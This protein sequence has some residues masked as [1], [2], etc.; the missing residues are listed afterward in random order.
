MSEFRT[1]PV[2]ALDCGGDSNACLEARLLRTRIDRFLAEFDCTRC[3]TPTSGS[4]PTAVEVRSV[5]RSRS[6]RQRYFEPKFC[7][8]PAWDMLLE[9][10]ATRLASAP[11]TV[12]S[13]CLV[14]PASTTTALRWINAF[15]DSGIVVRHP[16]LGDGRKVY[17]SLSDEAAGAMEAYFRALPDLRGV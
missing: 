2:V 7:R 17:L 8:D 13:L 16:D 5:L 15:E 6:L 1:R 11:V 12:S 9:L 14:A 4:L 3:S 10:Y